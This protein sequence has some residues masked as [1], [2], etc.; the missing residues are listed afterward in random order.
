MDLNSEDTLKLNVLLASKPLAVRVDESKMSVHGL[1][2]QGEKRIA[3]NPNC[4]DEIYLRRVRELI[5]GHVLGSP[6]GYPVYLR[7]WT[8]MGQTRDESLA[9]LLL[10][11]EPEA[12][13]AVVHALGLT[14][15]LAR[16]A[17]WAMPSAENARRMLEREAV[18]GAPIGRELAAYLLEY[19]PFETEPADMIDSV[20]LVLQ[21]GLIDDEARLSLWQRARQKTALLVGFMLGAP[22]ALPEPVAER[23]DLAE[24][25]SALEALAET[26]N[27]PAVLLLRILGGPGQ[28]YL[29]AC[30]RVMKKPPNQDVVNLFLDAVASYFGALRL[31]GDV[32]GDLAALQAAASELVDAPRAEPAVAALLERAP[33]LREDLRAA[34]VLSRLGYPVVRPVLGSTTAIGSL[35]RRKLEPVFGPLAAEIESLTRPAEV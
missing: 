30:L 3:L 1:S 5:S 32:E 34:L 6:G 26:G 2:E 11:G 35:M 8:R 25:R 28:T 24:L 19:L 23:A 4:R 31:P 13:V 29:R 15:E 20:R 7:R 27:A 12:V 9:Q 18:A 21:P 10:L 22:D 14:P 16:R 17:W 33:A